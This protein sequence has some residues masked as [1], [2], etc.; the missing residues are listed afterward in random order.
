MTTYRVDCI[1]PDGAD[2]DYAIDGLGGTKNDGTRW[3]D[4]KD[5]V[6]NAINAG[7][8]FYTSVGGQTADLLAKTTD[9][10]TRYVTTA[11]DSGTANNLLSLPGCS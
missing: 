1:T 6:W 5:A 11:P 8:R 7:D 10:G 2:S 3:K 9:R 4:T